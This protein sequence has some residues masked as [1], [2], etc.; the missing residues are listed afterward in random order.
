M[1]SQAKT[2]REAWD[3]GSHRIPCRAGVENPVPRSPS[4]FLSLPG[5]GSSTQFMGYPRDR[6]MFYAYLAGYQELGHQNWSGI[7]CRYC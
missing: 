1:V 4:H 6:W 7:V 3:L 2:G 5:L